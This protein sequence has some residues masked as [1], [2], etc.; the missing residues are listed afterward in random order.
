MIEYEADTYSRWLDNPD[1]VRAE[2]ANAFRMQVRHERWGKLVFA[3]RTAAPP[4][5]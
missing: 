5:T 3:G 4:V 2:L 1:F